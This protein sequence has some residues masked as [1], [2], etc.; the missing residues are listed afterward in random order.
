MSI[1]W[2]NYPI[3]PIIDALK[4]TWG[5]VL[6]I[7]FACALG[8]VAGAFILAGSMYFELIEVFALLPTLLFLPLFKG[9]I[10]AL[11]IYGTVAALF[12]SIRYCPNIRLELLAV[13]SITIAIEI[14]FA[15]EEGFEIAKIF[16][17]VLCLVLI[18]GVPVL[19]R[20][21]PRLLAKLRHG[22]QSDTTPE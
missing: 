8:F 1:W 9:E 17:L 7:I 5:I 19:L 22:R 14:S 10:W 15:F 12:I 18:A 4:E 2:N 11:S 20:F 13:L 21:G 16:R 6:G 3:S